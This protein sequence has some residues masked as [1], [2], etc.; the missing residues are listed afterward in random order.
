MAEAF[1]KGRGF[2]LAVKGRDGEDQAAFLAGERPG[3]VFVDVAIEPQAE[4]RR[5]RQNQRKKRGDSFFQ[6]SSL[7]TQR[8]TAAR[9][10]RTDSITE[11]A[12]RHK[13]FAQNRDAWERPGLFFPSK[14][15]FQ[16]A[17]Q[18]LERAAQGAGDGGFVDAQ[19][20]GD[21]GHGHAPVY[22]QRQYLP[23]AGRQ[24]RRHR[25]WQV[26]QQPL[27]ALAVVAG[28]GAEPRLKPRPVRKIITG[29]RHSRKS[30]G[31]S[32]APS[33]RTACG[34]G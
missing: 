32:T 10:T 23:L 22:V 14:A 6:P 19:L 31:R 17:A 27:A 18:P 12:R 1:D 15:V 24:L 21:L 5:Q 29:I 33:G 28:L 34:T 4:G 20:L 2:T 11:N 3:A 16:A 9:C 8:N 25:P 30:P 26:P 13:C 7:L